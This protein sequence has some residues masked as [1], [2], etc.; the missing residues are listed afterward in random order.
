MS[1]AVKIHS[2]ST[3]ALLIGSNIFMTAAWYGHLKHRS[4][5]ILG[6]ILVS[7]LIALPEYCL[8]VPANRFGYEHFTAFQLKIIQEAISL[9]V[10]CGFA[11]WYLGEPLKLNYLIAFLFLVCAVVAAFWK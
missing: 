2:L 6:A 1:H 8:Q 9:I 3:I 10:F 5:P 7:W 11:Y 4:Y